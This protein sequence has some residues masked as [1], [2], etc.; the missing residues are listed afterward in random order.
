MERQEIR[1]RN[2][3]GMNIYDMKAGAAKVEGQGREGWGSASED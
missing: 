3:N 1:T 2:S